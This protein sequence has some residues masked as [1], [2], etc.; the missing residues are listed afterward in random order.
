MDTEKWEEIFDKLSE[1]TA[2]AE[3]LEGNVADLASELAG[4]H[5]AANGSLLEA[6]AAMNEAISWIIEARDCF[7]G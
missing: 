6:Q 2:D 4:V 7:E 3:I 5:D 1:M